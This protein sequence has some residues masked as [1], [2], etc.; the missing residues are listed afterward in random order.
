MT[1]PEVC[2][3]CAGCGG[4]GI[5]TPGGLAAP[6]VFKTG[7]EVSEDAVQGRC[8]LGRNGNRAAGYRCVLASGIANWGMNWGT[9]RQADDTLSPSQI[10][11]GG[12]ADA[13]VNGSGLLNSPDVHPR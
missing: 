6:A 4:R 2:G 1:L 10:S 12:V 7:R 3:D 5:R 8:E 9:P 11:G 13:I